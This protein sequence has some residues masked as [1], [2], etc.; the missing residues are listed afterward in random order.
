MDGLDLSLDEI[1]NSRVDATVVR[2][3]NQRI[4]GRPLRG[5][6]VSMSELVYES[7]EAYENYIRFLKGLRYDDAHRD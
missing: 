6:G 5:V 1:K 2:K 3:R 7:P 4:F